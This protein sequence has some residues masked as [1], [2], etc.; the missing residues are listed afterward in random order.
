M[1]TEKKTIKIS[2]SQNEMECDRVSITFTSS[3][4]QTELFPG[5]PDL[6]KET[7]TDESSSVFFQK[8]NNILTTKLGE[9]CKTRI[10]VNNEP[11]FPVKTTIDYL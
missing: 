9:G 7:Q 8:L 2:E 6:V 11:I 10:K 4:Q 3:Q 1:E 5:Y